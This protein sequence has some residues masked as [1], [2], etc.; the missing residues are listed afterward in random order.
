MS[1]RSLGYDSDNLDRIICYFMKTILHLQ[2][3]GIENL[4]LLNNLDEP[5]RSFLDAAMEIFLSS[6]APE[7]SRL[8]LESEYDTILHCGHVSTETV[9]GL[10]LIKELTWHIHYDGDYYSY[11]LSTDNLWGNSALEYATLTFYPNL[12]ENVKAKYRIY[13]LI[14]YVPENMLRL[15]DF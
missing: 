8:I 13:N 3:S 7:L 15:N 14:Q 1:V 10:Q 4:P 12:P 11:L 2:T 9:I 6:P 5:W